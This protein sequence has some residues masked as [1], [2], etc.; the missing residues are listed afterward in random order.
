[1][2]LSDHVESLDWE[3]RNAEFLGRISEATLAEVTY[4][5]ATLIGA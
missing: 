1:M 2:T 5:I 3:S 4:R